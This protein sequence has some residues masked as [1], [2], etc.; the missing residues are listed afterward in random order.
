MTAHPRLE[1]QEIQTGECT[2]RADV[3][4]KAWEKGQRARG[5]FWGWVW[6]PWLPELPLSLFVS[7]FSFCMRPPPITSLPRLE[8]RWVSPL[9]MGQPEFPM[10]YHQTKVPLLI[11]EP[12]TCL[13]AETFSKLLC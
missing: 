3:T 12:I 6:E 4:G 7:W 2:G 10:D 13:A 9:G 1:S 11:D 8:L 5:C